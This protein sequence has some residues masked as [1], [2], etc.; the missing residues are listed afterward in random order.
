MVVVTQKW[1]SHATF[2][3][4]APRG[5][6]ARLKSDILERTTVQNIFSKIGFSTYSPYCKMI[7]D[8]RFI[9]GQAKQFSLLS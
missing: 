4:Y 8:M 2:S 1:L 6:N 5:F 7:K 9:Q 3:Y